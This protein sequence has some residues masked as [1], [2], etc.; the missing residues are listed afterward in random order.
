MAGVKHE[1]TTHVSASGINLPVS[2]KL[3]KKLMLFTCFVGLLRGLE[4]FSLTMIYILT[5]S[6]GSKKECKIA[7]HKVNNEG[8][9]SNSVYNFP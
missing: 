4:P 6:T 5:L 2:G 9:F 3:A 8:R 1:C 7:N